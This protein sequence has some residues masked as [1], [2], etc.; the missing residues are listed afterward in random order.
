MSINSDAVFFKLSV[1]HGNIDEKQQHNHS[2]IHKLP[3][4]ELRCEVPPGA[5]PICSLSQ[6]L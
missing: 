4:V 6:D 2:R 5:L 3:H 1:L